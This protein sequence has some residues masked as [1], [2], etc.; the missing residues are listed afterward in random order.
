MLLAVLYWRKKS[1]QP[2]IS[3]DETTNVNQS[4]NDL[5][6]NH[7][8]NLTLNT[9][10]I[11]A[12]GEFDM[13]Y[14]LDCR[15]DQLTIF[16]NYQ[17]LPKLPGDWRALAEISCQYLNQNQELETIYLPLHI[18]QPNTQQLLFVGGSIKQAEETEILKYVEKA[19]QGFY[20]AMMTHALGAKPEK[21]AVIKIVAN[22]PAERFKKNET[23]GVAFDTLLEANPPYTQDDLLKLYQTGDSQYLPQIDGKPYFW[24]VVGY[25]F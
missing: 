5:T 22:Y 2:S 6:D 23:N 13:F 16:R 20:E 8:A 21:G 19:D 24:P 11:E 7:L 10:P 4:A 18:Y 14:R 12:S 1:F 25:S 17:Q 3:L 15:Y 9:F